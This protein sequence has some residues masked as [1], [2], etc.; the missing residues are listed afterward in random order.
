M[1]RSDYDDCEDQWRYIMWR[2]AVE[3]ARRGRKGQALLK[4]MNDEWCRRATPAQRFAM[5]RAWVESCINKEKPKGG[6]E[7]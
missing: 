1:S 2:G 3:S 7:T 4:D 5:M 6:D